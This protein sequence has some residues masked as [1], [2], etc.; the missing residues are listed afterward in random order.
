VVAVI[1][2]LVLNSGSGGGGAPSNQAGQSVSSA[3]SATGTAPKS[4]S[5]SSVP[6]GPLGDTTTDGKVTNVGAAGLLVVNFFS[7]P[8]SSWSKLTPA[9]QA[10]Y[11]SEQQFQTYWAANKS[12]IHGFK[13]ANADSGRT[14]DDGSLII[15]MDLNDQS[16][17]PFRIVMAGGQ[18]LIDS[19]TKLDGSTSSTSGQ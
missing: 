6:A 4:S 12:N 13:K 16:R 14:E 11:G 1:V 17:R 5:S 10:V 18:M 2:F 9:A 19:S 3:P 8:A 7:D 15:N